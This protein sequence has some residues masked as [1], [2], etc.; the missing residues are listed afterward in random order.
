MEDCSHTKQSLGAALK[1]LRKQNKKLT[2]ELTQAQALF[3]STTAQLTLKNRREARHMLSVGPSEETKQRMLVTALSKLELYKKDAAFYQN[4]LAVHE[5]SDTIISELRDNMDRQQRVIELE[6]E[7]SQRR[8]SSKKEAAPARDEEVSPELA[9]INHKLKK[10]NA[11]KTFIKG[12]EESRNA[13]EVKRQAGEDWLNSLKEKQLKLTTELDSLPDPSSY[14]L[15]LMS[16]REVS[17]QLKQAEE[18]KH[19]A[20]SK[21]RAR[22]AELIK[23]SLTLQKRELRLKRDLKLKV[24]ELERYKG[25]F[26]NLSPDKLHLNYNDSYRLSSFRSRH[27]HTFSFEESSVT[28]D[29]SADAISVLSRSVL[30]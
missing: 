5:H 22:E 19:Y 11:F 4:Q 17:T 7:V 23:E 8:A 13:N 28:Q 3:D 27:S 18:S 20:V 30:G 10:L 25:T 15:I 9:K 2:E 21:L 26:R 14:K 16:K 1:E 6:R 29:S 24:A 12:L